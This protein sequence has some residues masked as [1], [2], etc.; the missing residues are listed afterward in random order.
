MSPPAQLEELSQSTGGRSQLRQ[1]VRRDPSNPTLC[2]VLNRRSELV[3]RRRNGQAAIGELTR[4]PFRAGGVLR[5]SRTTGVIT[6]ERRTPQS[7]NLMQ[8]QHWQLEPKSSVAIVDD[9]PDFRASVAGLLQSV[10]LHTRSFASVE[11]YLSSE[12]PDC[13]TCLVLDVRMPG[14]SG[15]DFQR[16]LVAANAELPIIFI[17]GHGDIPMSVQAMKRGAVE[18]LTKPFRDQELIDAVH[19]GL[20]RDRA[21]LIR[22]LD[23]EQLQ[24]SQAAPLAHLLRQAMGKPDSPVRQPSAAPSELLTRREVSILK[25]LESGLSNKEI[26]EAI[27]VSEGTLKWHLHN[28]YSKLGVKNR[29]GAMS[30]ARALGMIEGR[31]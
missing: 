30:R 6:N 19:V 10:G 1:A 3:H 12:P 5:A 13:P 23:L 26:A 9:D 8:C 2:P 7:R 28:V 15:L 18:F 11:E 16:D 20:A 14:Q 25:R 21:R 4:G 27:F 31:W 22:R 24:G 29:S 17:T